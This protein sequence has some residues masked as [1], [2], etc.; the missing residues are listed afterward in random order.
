MWFSPES[1]KEYAGYL[2]VH[3]MN[4]HYLNERGCNYVT[5]GARNISHKTNVH[6]FLQD[7]FRFR[8]AYTTLN[9]VY[10]P[11]VGFAVRCLYPFRRF[12]RGR[13]SSIL[14]KIRVLLQL[15]YIHRTC[16]G[17]IGVADG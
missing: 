13:S 3:E 8:R 10:A 1:L 2:L 11:G 6:D 12:F 4:K 15:E 7:K 16:K 14:G 5:D 17:G 9:V